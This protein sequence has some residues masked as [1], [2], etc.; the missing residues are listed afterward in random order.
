[1]NY[2][3]VAHDSAASR[4]SD[5]EARAGQSV[6]LQEIFGPKGPPAGTGS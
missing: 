3:L 4:D 5:P 6:T 1:M 2:E